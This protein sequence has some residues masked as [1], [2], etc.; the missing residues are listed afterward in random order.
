MYFYCF[1]QR[2]GGDKVVDITTDAKVKCWDYVHIDGTEALCL[3]DSVA[4]PE[5]VTSRYKG[6]GEIQIVVKKLLKKESLELLQRFVDHWFSSYK[7]SLPLYL[8][9][10]FE[11][12]LNK[13][14]LKKWKKWE[15]QSLTIFPTVRS[16]MQ[17]T[18]KAQRDNPH[19][20][21]LHSATTTVQKAKAF[22]WIKQWEITTVYCTYS[23]IFQDWNNLV[24]ITLH[25]QHSWRYKNQQDPRWYVPTV[26]EYMAKH[27]DAKL[28]TTWRKLEA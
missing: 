2:Y 4:F 13:N 14:P 28:S 16:L 7:N 25:N 18:T 19:S 22:W 11:T 1:N 3:G 17:E 27:Y 12:I 6:K 10:S 15:E 5:L 9:S 23:Q 24:S 8:T 20:V 21:I 26:V